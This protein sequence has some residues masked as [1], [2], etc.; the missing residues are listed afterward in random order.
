MSKKN[1]MERMRRLDPFESLPRERKYDCWSEE[2]D[3]LRQLIA[4]ATGRDGDPNVLLQEEVQ[5]YGGRLA[6]LR[7]RLRYVQRMLDT[8]PM[9]MVRQAR[10]FRPSRR[11]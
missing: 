4:G 7:E 6:D 2:A 8:P 11:P 5:K 1:F 3:R 9:K 10:N